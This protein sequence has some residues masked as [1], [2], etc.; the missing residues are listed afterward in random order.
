M[1]T[2][3]EMSKLMKN[4]LLNI[5]GKLWSLEKP[6]VM[7]ILNVTPDSFYA[8]SRQ[9]NETAVTARIESII[10]E[11]GA[12][13][14]IGGYSTRPDAPEVTPEEEWNRLEPGLKILMKK[15]PDVPVSIDTFRAV[16]A[17]RAVE[18][19]GVAMVN[20]ISGGAKD[21]QMFETVAKIQ[22]PYIL[23]HFRETSQSARTPS[24]NDPH[25]EEVPLFFAEKLRTLRLA[26]VNDVLLDPGFGFGKNLD[27]NYEL[28]RSLPDFARLFT[29][30][31]VVG[32]SRKRMI[33][34]LLK[35]SAEESLNGTTVLHTFALLHGTDIL[36]VHDVKAAV[37]AIIL[38]NKIK[39]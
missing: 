35:C 28:L 13:I 11:G 20:D 4:K 14:D 3:V 16:I 6:A 1:H 32:I 2:I 7:G 18:D 5:K 17:R 34:N 37:E 9:T 29:C 15:F 38:V 19:Y 24:Q 10:S 22:V 39:C 33:Y 30:P 27:E 12:L 25:H 26:G 36:R 21:D 31:M 23:T 8:A